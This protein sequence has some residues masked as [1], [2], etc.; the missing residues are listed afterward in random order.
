MVFLWK[1]LCEAGFPIENATK[2]EIWR[3]F[4]SRKL[5]GKVNKE[6]APDY[7]DGVKKQFLKTKQNGQL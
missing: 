1:K 3:V 4:Y 5:R 2:S 7:I 6:V